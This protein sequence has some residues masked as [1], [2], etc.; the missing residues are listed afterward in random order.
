MSSASPPQRKAAAK[1]HAKLSNTL[2]HDAVIQ[3]YTDAAHSE[4]IAAIACYGDEKSATTTVSRAT[5]DNT[6]NSLELMAIHLAISCTKERQHSTHC[7]YHVYTDSQ[8]TYT[9]WSTGGAEDGILQQIRATVRRLRAATLQKLNG[10]PR[11][12]E[13]PETIRYTSQRVQL[14]FPHLCL[15]PTLLSL[16]GCPLRSTSPTCPSWAWRTRGSER[17]ATAVAPSHI[18]VTLKDVILH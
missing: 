14:A 17:I 16:H 4:K 15:A 3:L 9:A 8:A 1:R 6:V 18:F 13:S 11:T 10:F 5:L 2:A 12:K 7:T